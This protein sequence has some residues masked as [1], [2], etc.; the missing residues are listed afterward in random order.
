MREISGLTDAGNGM[1]AAIEDENGIL[2]F[3]NAS[4]GKIHATYDFGK[5][6]DYEAVEK[7]G[8]RFYV[9]K[10]NGDLTHFTLHQGK[11]NDIKTLDTDF[12]SAN[13]IEGLAVFNNQFLVA[14]KADPE[15]KKNDIRGKAIYSLNGDLEV[16]PKPIII[17]DE[18]ML[19]KWIR[20]RLPDVRI[21]DFDP[22]GVAVDPIS[23]Y[24]YIISAD[25]ILSV[26]TQDG[27]LLEVVLL[28][29]KI[30]RQPEG[31]SFDARGNLFI[32]SEGSGRKARLFVLKRK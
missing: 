8:D 15:V 5:R 12:S 2:Y 10:S 22:S 18:E 24:V 3:L 1:L 31:L 19:E 6:G 25:H 7:L 4:N 9:M 32:S 20:K 23:G 27:A 16:Q 13:D 14:C 11:V 17:L 28:D 26:F 21:N 30:Y 29:K